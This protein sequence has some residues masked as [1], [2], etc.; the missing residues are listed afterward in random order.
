MRQKK[1]KKTARAVSFYRVNYGLHEPFK[2]LLD[3]NFIHA[4]MS[5]K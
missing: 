2:V 3:G 5:A 4:A 1:H